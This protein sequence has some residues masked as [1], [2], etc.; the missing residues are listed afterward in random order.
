MDGF[1]AG[2][3]VP[4][5]FSAC[6]AVVDKPLRAR[7]SESRL[8]ALSGEDRVYGDLNHPRGSPGEDLLVPGTSYS[9][10]FR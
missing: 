6:R 4:W 3:N 9:G 8:L 2:D 5:N 7:F 1:H 10:D